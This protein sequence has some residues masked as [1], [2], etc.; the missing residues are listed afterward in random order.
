MGPSL[1]APSRLLD[2]GRPNRR[3]TIATVC[4]SLAI[5]ASK[6]WIRS[7][8]LSRQR[9]CLVRA[10][11]LKLHSKAVHSK[12]EELLHGLLH[13]MRPSQFLEW[14]FRKKTDVHNFSACNSRARDGCANIMGACNVLLFLQEKTSMPINFLILDG[15]FFCWGGGGAKVTI[16]FMGTG[17]FVSCGK[18]E[19]KRTALTL[20]TIIWITLLAPSRE[21]R[22]MVDTKSH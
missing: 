1:R 11:S 6:S 3:I 5:W 14:L 16:I 12:A 4:K 2:L 13:Q 7:L 8:T 19:Q 9:V 10:L 22:P 17:I 18:E 21:S 15:F 20:T